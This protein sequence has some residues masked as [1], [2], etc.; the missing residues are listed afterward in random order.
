MIDRVLANIV[1]LT[2]FGFVLFVVF[3]GL[4]LFRWKRL[5]WA[6]LPAAVWGALIE[7][8]GWVCPLTPLEIWLRTRAGISRY[9][10]GFLEHYVFAL[11]YPEGLTRTMQFA[12]AAFV[13]VINVLVYWMAFRRQNHSS[14]SSSAQ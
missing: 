6:H 13:V 1:V 12:L 3:G 4:L 10:E 5:V 2:H 11:L 14:A 8:F 7:I 9:D